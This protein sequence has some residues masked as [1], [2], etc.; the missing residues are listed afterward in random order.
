MADF[1][2]RAAIPLYTATAYFGRGAACCHRHEAGS[3]PK[4]PFAPQSKTA[5]SD[6]RAAILLFQQAG[7]C[8]LKPRRFKVN[9]VTKAVVS[10]G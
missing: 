1:S 4:Q 10:G 7:E 9:S 6:D 3:R 5:T 8:L 2:L